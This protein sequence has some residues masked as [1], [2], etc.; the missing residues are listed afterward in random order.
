MPAPPPLPASRPARMAGVGCGAAASGHY[1]WNNPTMIAQLFTCM[2]MSGPFLT[3]YTQT[4]NDW[5]DRD[6]DAINEPYRP[7]PSGRISESDV[8]AQVWKA[9]ER[10]G[11]RAL[12]VDAGAARRMLRG[13]RACAA[14]GKMRDQFLA[15]LLG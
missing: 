15:A 8:I 12:G 1:E 5:Y 3:G 6:I 7:I 9:P 4:I 10:A 2:A 13:G 11:E 14:C